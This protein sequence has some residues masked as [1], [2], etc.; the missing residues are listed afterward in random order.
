MSFWA[1]VKTQ[2]KDLR[3]FEKV[4]NRNDVTFDRKGKN[5]NMMMD[6]RVAGYLTPSD[7]KAWTLN[8]DNDVSYSPFSR[9]F[10]KNGGTLM[11]DYAA[12]V[13][14]VQMVANG[15]FVT[16]RSEQ[17]DGSIVMRIRR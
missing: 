6:G 12:E 4:C 2:I 16:S 8:V 1:S 15:G 5:I 13:V 17:K 3:T 14:Q 7:G 10:G 11:R 9:K